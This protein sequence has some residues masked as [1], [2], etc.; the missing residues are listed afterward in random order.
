MSHARKG[1]PSPD[2][3]RMLAALRVARAGISEEFPDCD[4]KREI[5]RHLDDALGMIAESQRTRRLSRM[6]ALEEDRRRRGVSTIVGLRDYIPDT[7]GV[8]NEE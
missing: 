3:G 1:R 5:L 7:S 4:A 8:T 6:L 2:H